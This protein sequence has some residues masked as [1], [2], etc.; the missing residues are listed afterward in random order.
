MN[1]G[2]LSTNHAAPF[3][4]LPVCEPQLDIIRKEDGSIILSNPIKLNPFA[5]NLLEYLHH[6]DKERPNEFFMGQRNEK[7]EWDRVTFSQIRLRADKIGQA[8]QKAGLKSGDSL[9]IL[10]P[11]SINHAAIIL[12]SMY[13]E[14]ITSSISPNYSLMAQDFA[15]LRYI[16]NKMRP[17]AFYVEDYA[18]YE[19]AIKSLDLPND[20]III[21]AKNAN[22]NPNVISLEEFENSVPNAKNFT[23]DIKISPETI[24]RIFFTSG[25]TGWPKGVIKT[26]HMMCSNLSVGESIWTR[27]QLAPRRVISWMPWNHTMAGT[28]M[29]NQT[30]RCGGTFYIDDGRP[31]TP[32]TYARTV[33][34]LADVK[35]DFIADAPLGLA[36]LAEAFE[37]DKELAKEVLANVKFIIYAGA[38]LP[39]D[40]WQRLQN[41]F[42]EV[43]GHRLQVYSGFG[44]TETGPEFCQVYWPVEGAGF[45][46]LPLPGTSAKLIPI[47]NGRYEVRMKGIS[48]TQG[49]IED[50]EANKNAFDEDGFLKMGD[51]LSF[52]DE[53]DPMQGLKFAG[54]LAEDFKLLSGTF[55]SAGG[56][57]LALLSALSPYVRELVIT[58]DN[59]KEIGALIWLNEEKVLKDLDLKT[60]ISIAELKAL[61]ELK[62]LLSKHLGEYNKTAGGGSK[63]IK[64]LLVLATP[65]SSDLNEITDKGYINRRSVLE[66]R[67]NE[68]TKLYDDNSNEIIKVGG[69]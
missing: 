53:N 54:R 65:P 38:A 28:V 67:A 17:K 11:H 27:D 34:N 55:V 14:I 4:E 57:R 32:Q 58:G 46:G 42:V 60:D 44:S 18:I 63:T 8:L 69:V 22:N 59:Q 47:G 48:Q 43:L 9:I 7:G 23:D 25:S 29:F 21:A 33:Q 19:K 36:Y 39:T 26:H 5:D 10:S 24:V 45:A 31:I 64:R 2:D 37:E 16:Y 61:P 20:T 49:Y 1:K 40:L 62:T 35:P 68:V 6:W 51:A 52:V 41:V 3:L 12:G 30:L 15:K 50:E 56:L 13:G 66:A